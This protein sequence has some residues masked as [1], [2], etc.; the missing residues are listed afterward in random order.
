MTAN[1]RNFQ[2]KNGEKYEQKR[3]K[4]EGNARKMEELNCLFL[5][6]KLY[7]VIRF[8]QHTFPYHSRE[9]YIRIE[10]WWLA[11]CNLAFHSFAGMDECRQQADGKESERERSKGKRNKNQNTKEMLKMRQTRV[12]LKCV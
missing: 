9:N 7:F 1:V 3:D 10:M 11:D 8:C 4:T 2:R 12:S 6:S 5:Y